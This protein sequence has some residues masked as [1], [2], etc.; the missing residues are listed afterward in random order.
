MGDWAGGV[1]WGT[2]KCRADQSRAE[3]YVRQ[4][5]EGAPQPL[6]AAVA[7]LDP[8]HA[9]GLHIL[10]RTSALLALLSVALLLS[11]SPLHTFALPR[12]RVLSS[13]T[14]VQQLGTHFKC[15]GNMLIPVCLGA[16]SHMLWLS[17]FLP[18]HAGL[19]VLY[20]LWKPALY[21]LYN[22]YIFIYNNLHAPTQTFSV[23]LL[24]Y[25]PKCSPPSSSEDGRQEGWV[26][27]VTSKAV[28]GGRITLRTAG[29][30]GTWSEGWGQPAER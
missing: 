16:L 10:P 21:I 14:G 5:C 11:T 24:E 22:V 9:H 28:S 25:A 17:L 26:V 4:D 12:L 13:A 23:A 15:T 6:P 19:G 7:A 18:T 1:T 30:L 27:R 29:Q 20:I 3:L 2:S 8:M